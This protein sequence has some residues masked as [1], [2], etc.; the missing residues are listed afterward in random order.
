MYHPASILLSLAA[1]AIVAS[2]APQA[3]KSSILDHPYA[4]FKSSDC[5]VLKACKSNADCTTASCA[6][7]SEGE[8]APSAGRY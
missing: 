2:A 6:V 4:V 1:L 8:C 3:T 5:A 7:C